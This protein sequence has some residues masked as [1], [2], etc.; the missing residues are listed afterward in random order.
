[1]KEILQTVPDRPVKFQGQSV[2]LTDW[3]L[4]S[5]KFVTDRLETDTQAINNNRQA[6]NTNRQTGNCNRPASYCLSVSKSVGIKG[7]IG[8]QFAYI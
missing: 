4:E 1:M 3:V 8:R 7:R 2:T 6:C 5:G